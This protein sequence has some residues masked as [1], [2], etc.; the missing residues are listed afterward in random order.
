MNNYFGYNIGQ[1]PGTDLP[2]VKG[3]ESARMFPTAPNSRVVVF[4]EDEDVF[5]LIESDSSNFKSSVRRFRF[6]E[7][8]VR[9]SY[10]RD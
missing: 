7:E 8:S 5:Y 4:D 6:T 2:R 9:R 3:I 10:G 1:L